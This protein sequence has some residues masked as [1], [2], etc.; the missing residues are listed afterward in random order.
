MRRWC[1]PLLGLE[2]DCPAVSYLARRRELGAYAAGRTLLR[3]SGIRVFLVDSGPV[4]GQEHAEEVTTP[5][6]LASAVGGRAHE[7]VALER[8]AARAADATG[9]V[10]EFLDEAAG[11]LAAAARAA[12]AFVCAADGVT[13][14]GAGVP[15]PTEVRR[16]AGR[17]LSARGAPEPVLLRHLLWGALET[18]RPLQLRCTDPVPLTPLLHAAAGRGTLVLLPRT[19]H[20]AAAARL[21]AAFPH[22]YADVGPEPGRTLAEAPSG[23]LLFSSRARALPELHVIRARRFQRAM[24]RVLSDWVTAGECS[25]ADAERVGA[26]VAGGTARRIYRLTERAPAR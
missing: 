3:A 8:L 17:W 14:G 12:A 10:E 18:G 26:M 21:A 25:P 9:T 24:G 20:H 2:P 5:D 13:E 4:P 22:V 19:P 15:E 7:L 23:K 16:A 6:E 11:A 1:P